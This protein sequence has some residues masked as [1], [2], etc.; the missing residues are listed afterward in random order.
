MTEYISRRH[1][2]LMTFYGHI[3]GSSRFILI[4]LIPPIEL[5]VT[6]DSLVRKHYFILF[7]MPP[8]LHFFHWS[9]F[10]LSNEYIRYGVIVTSAALASAA[11]SQPFLDI[12]T[13]YHLKRRRWRMVIT[14]LFFILII[15]SFCRLAH[16]FHHTFFA[17]MI[18]AFFS[19]LRFLSRYR[20]LEPAARVKIGPWHAFISTLLFAHGVFTLDDGDFDFDFIGFAMTSSIKQN[21]L[22]YF[23]ISSM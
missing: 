16:Y 23:D 5:R 19:I 21:I 1:R 2:F 8:R 20:A 15:I 14:F 7:S 9:I 11:M 13:Q 12:I 22:W 17:A 6:L 3:Q 4:W 10:D 18:S